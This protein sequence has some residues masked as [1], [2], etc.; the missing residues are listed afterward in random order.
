MPN[1][2]VIVLDEDT[3]RVNTFLGKLQAR[4]LKCVVLDMDR[5]AVRQH[6]SGILR[7]TKFTSYCES[8]SQDV[9]LIIPILHARGVKIAFA[10][11]TDEKYYDFKPIST[12]IAGDDL[13]NAVAEYHFPDIAS[14]IYVCGLQPELWIGSGDPK[15]ELPNNKTP[16]ISEIAAFFKIKTSEIVLFDD[17]ARNIR[18]NLEPPNQFVA[19]QVTGSKAFCLD[20]LL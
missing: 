6:S 10:S 19:M 17:T 3:E 18:E 11:F 14:D 4:G 5:T 15:G 16:H 20:D 13:L 1:C 8:V 7:R 2:F 9:K 12:H